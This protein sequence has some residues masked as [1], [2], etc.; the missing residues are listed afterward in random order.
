MGEGNQKDPSL[1]SARGRSDTEENQDVMEIP[2]KSST[3]LSM[4]LQ[5]PRNSPGQATDWQFSE[6]K[7]QKEISQETQ[8]EL[9]LVNLGKI[10][11]VYSKGSVRQLKE[12]KLLFEAF[13]QGSTEGPTRHRK[14]PA[15]FSK[16][17]GVLGHVYPSVLE[18]TRSLEVLYN[19]KCALPRTSSLRLQ[20]AK[21]SCSDGDPSTERPP[22]G[23]RAKR[24]TVIAE[25]DA[26]PQRLSRSMESLSLEDG[27]KEG[28][29]EGPGGGRRRG[30]GEAGE[31]S[32]APTE[33]PFFKLRPALA[34]KPEVEKDIREARERDEDLRRQRCSLYGKAKGPS[35][36]DDKPSSPIA[37]HPAPAPGQRAG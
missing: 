2:F 30:K 3:L 22:T 26:G 6:K 23:K 31:A 10:P 12:K 9:V 28:T 8:R 32:P 27:E 24:Q 1:R 36:E 14:A 13:Q 20:R 15:F 16:G 5:P 18:R 34:L 17:L 4:P 7:M 33:N 19:K 11:G 21:E 25:G 29:G 37:A 35:T